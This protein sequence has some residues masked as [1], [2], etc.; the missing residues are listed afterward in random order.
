MKTTFAVPIFLVSVL[1]FALA[2][3]QP[4]TRMGPQRKAPA[5]SAQ[6]G[7]S[8]ALQLEHDWTQAYL[9]HDVAA[10]E[11]VLA[12]DW[13]YSPSDGSFKT[14]SQYIEEFRVDTMKYQSID[15]QNVSV[16][17]Y[18]NTAVVRGEEVI[19]ATDSGKPV[20]LHIRFTDV[21]VKTNG[22][23][24]AVASHESTIPQAT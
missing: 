14:R 20:T 12:D 9:N 19:K 6:P 8:A 11:L 5:T 22:R 23:W 1:A 21:L 15:Q 7:E 17:I 4:D 10:L 16:R 2:A 3:Q 18:G 24:H 13:T